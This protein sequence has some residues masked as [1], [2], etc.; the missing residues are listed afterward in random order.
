MEGLGVLAIV[1]VVGLVIWG[2]VWTHKK[3][4]ERQAALTAWANDRSGR[5]DPSRDSSF[6]E[7]YPEFKCLREGSARYAYNRIEVPRAARPF[8]AF[9]YH[10]ETYS[11]DSKGHRHTHHHYFSALLLD[12]GLP[13]KPLFLRP[14]GFFDKVTELFGADDIDFESHRFSREF[15]VK[16]PDRKWAFD[17]IHQATMEFLLESPRFT[18]ETIGRHLMVRRGSRFK[19]PDYAVALAV[20]DGI[21]D[22]LPKYLLQELQGQGLEGRGGRA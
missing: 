9:D 20:A 18:I 14:E 17:V 21:L 19:V 10:Y 22:R 2:I 7:R 4:K 1:A 8:L 15:Y 12:T 6:D 5:F 16:S 3:E 13:L 11:T